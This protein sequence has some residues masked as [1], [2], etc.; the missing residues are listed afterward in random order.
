MLLSEHLIHTVLYEAWV[1]YILY[2]L[3]RTWHDHVKYQ[4]ILWKFTNCFWTEMMCSYEINF[5]YVIGKGTNTLCIMWHITCLI[6]KPNHGITWH[7]ELSQPQKRIIKIQT[8]TK[9][10]LCDSSFPVT[11]SQNTT[12]HNI[13]TWY[14]QVSSEFPLI[15]WH[16][17]LKHLY[18][19]IYAYVYIYILF[20]IVWA[21]NS[22]CRISAVYNV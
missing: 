3:C 14:I 21:P 11:V 8:K 2:S 10:I 19:C 7:N 1:R 9:Q 22:F 16:S 17:S 20:N 6:I 18:T 15:V 12:N 13:I 5:S 4:N